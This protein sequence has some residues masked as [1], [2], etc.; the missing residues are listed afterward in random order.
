MK[1][2]QARDQPAPGERGEDANRND[3]GAYESRPHF[4]DPLC[5]MREPFRSVDRQSLPV[6]RRSHPVLISNEK[7]HP[8]QRFK[9]LDVVTD[10]SVAQPEFFSC[11][12]IASM[13]CRSL[14]RSKSG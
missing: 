6:L 3:P 1:S 4:L 5:Q 13:S 2:A 10:R 11:T 7:R 12:R 8:E 14:E 9:A